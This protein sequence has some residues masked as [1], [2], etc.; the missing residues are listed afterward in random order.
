MN[1]EYANKYGKCSVSNQQEVR[2]TNK[3]VNKI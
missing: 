2:S 1:E 3:Y